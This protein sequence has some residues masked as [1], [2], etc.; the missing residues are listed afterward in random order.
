MSI[1]SYTQTYSDNRKILFDFHN[2]DNVDIYFRNKLDRTYYVF[3]N[4]T[5]EY[6]EKI[7]NTPYIQNIHNANVITL[8]NITFTESFTTML[9]KIKEDG[10]KY[11]FIFQDDV[12]SLTTRE[13]IDDL[14][15]FVRTHTF[16]MLYVEIP[17]INT[18][19]EIIYSTKH[20]KIYNTSSADFVNKNMY[21]LDDGPCVAN[22]D[23]LLEIYND[24]NFIKIGD[25][26]NA[27]NYT[28]RK[29]RNGVNIQRLSTNITLFQRVCLVGQNGLDQKDVHIKLL[30]ETHSKN[31]LTLSKR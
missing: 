2:N 16:D 3:H 15:D 26:W 20:L 25:V 27:E 13:I 6:I 7:C 4:S 1:C 22:I 10:F 19:K 12:F 11:V 14:L 8:R 28:D 24:P 30:N 29:I 23:F 17:N 21:A 5:D 18:D 31:E 9:M